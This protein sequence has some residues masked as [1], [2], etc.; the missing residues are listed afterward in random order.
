MRTKH[1]LI[2]TLLLLTFLL[3]ACAGQATPNVS[4]AVNTAA[5]AINT[6]AAS[7]AV[8]T[9]VGAVNTLAAST[10]VQTA[11]VQ[12]FNSLVAALQTAGLTV[13]TGESVTQPFFTV[14][15]QTL[16][17]NGQDI[18]VFAYDTAQAMEA[19]AAQIAPD[20]GTIGTSMPS[21]VSDPHFYKLG[22]MLVL[23]VGQDQ[24][25]LDILSGFLG[26]QFAGR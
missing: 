17:I 25:I 15:G 26:P 20:A 22:N 11:V 4:G 10:E 7:T 12:D 19:E 2:S 14:P 21:W 8:E 5:P 9:A 24:K 16:K 3:A 23:Y 6:L 13:E 1:F 18:Q